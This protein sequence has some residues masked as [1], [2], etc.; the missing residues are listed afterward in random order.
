MAAGNW[1]GSAAGSGLAF[2]AAVSAVCMVHMARGTSLGW[3]ESVNDTPLSVSAESGGAGDDIALQLVDANVLEIQAKRRLKADSELWGSLIAL[4]RRANED[5]AFHGVLAVGPSTSV[6][7]RDQ[8]ARDIIRLGQGR[9]DDLSPLAVTLTEKLSDAV[10]PLATSGRVR[11]QTVHVLEQNSASA[12]AAL[13]HLAH[14]TTQP[15]QAWERLQAEGLRLIQ[16]RGRHDIAS[17]AGIIPGLRASASSVNEL[18]EG[19]PLWPD[20][21]FISCSLFTAPCR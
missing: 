19:R 7:I 14:V 4:Y 15:E 2:Q 12:Q 18:R 6:S 21:S 5:A 20:Y 9:A 8:L 13:A 16:L 10:I 17:I 3:C 11:I 1:G